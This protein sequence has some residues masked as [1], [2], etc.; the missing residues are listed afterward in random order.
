M[1][2]SKQWNEVK[3]P[4]ND[5]E[6]RAKLYSC[7]SNEYFPKIK[8]RLNQ[9]KNFKS[10]DKKRFKKVIQKK[11]KKM[12]WKVLVKT[13]RCLI[14]QFTKLIRYYLRHLSVSLEKKHNSQKMLLC[15][16]DTKKGFYERNN[17]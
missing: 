14:K 3:Q 11:T 16:S 6:A 7:L 15:K 13:K 12:V 17:W 5:N 1:L 2:N 10:L 4:N 9:T 8:N